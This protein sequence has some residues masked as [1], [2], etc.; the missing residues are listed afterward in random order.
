VKR[1]RE[2]G[3]EAGKERGGEGEEKKK[4]ELLA[5][6]AGG[7]KRRPR[8]RIPLGINRAKRKGSIAVGLLNGVEVHGGSEEESSHVSC[9]TQR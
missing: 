9:H 8:F 2:E 3:R 5:L 4:K 1:E 6:C 7:V